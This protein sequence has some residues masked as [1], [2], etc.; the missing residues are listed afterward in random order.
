MSYTLLGRDLLTKLKA[1]IRFTRTRPEV[2]R[3]TPISMVLAL[4]VEEQYQL[5]DFLSQAKIPDMKEWMTFP[6]PWV[7]TGGMGMAV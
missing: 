1:Q 6:K 3:K 5:H 4:R 2:T 7:E